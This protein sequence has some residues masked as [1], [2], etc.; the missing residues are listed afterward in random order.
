[1]F[2]SNDL[3]YT[4]SHH[5]VAQYNSGI[6]PTSF[7]QPSYQLFTPPTQTTS[8]ALPQYEAQSSIRYFAPLSP[9][10]SPSYLFFKKE[11]PKRF[12]AKL[13]EK[14]EQLYY[15]LKEEFPHLE[16]NYRTCLKAF[17]DLYRSECPVLF[18]SESLMYQTIMD[19][20]FNYI[21]DSTSSPYKTWLWIKD[22]CFQN[23]P[24]RSGRLL[25]MHRDTFEKTIKSKEKIRYI[26]FKSSFWER[27]FNWTDVS[28]EQFANRFK[29]QKIN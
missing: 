21:L 25:H 15:D 6:I 18:C 23:R 2:V 17:C 24:T 3:S 8:Y 10:A 14:Q 1:M 28:V 5:H 19:S 26:P 12:Q 4:G 20:P 29:Y 16:H 13:S 9:P 22:Y 11:T 27:M 7:A